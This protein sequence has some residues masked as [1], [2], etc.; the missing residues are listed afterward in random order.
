MKRALSLILIYL[1]V[2]MLCGCTIPVYPDSGLENGEKTEEPENPPTQSTKA[3]M[4]KQSYDGLR[5][6][7]Y[8]PEHPTENTPL[9]V[10]LHGGSGKGE[11]P[12]LI[13][14]VDGFPKYV[15]DGD[16]VPHAYV[17]FPQCPSDQNGWAKMSDKLE[18]LI[19]S[20]CSEL[21]ID[22]GRIS[23]TGHSMGGT[24]TWSLALSKPH[25]FYK[26]APMSGSVKLTDANVSKLSSLSIR[27]F[28][29]EADRMV[30]PE[31]SKVMISA[32]KELGADADIT[33]FLG[34]THA[35]VPA[36]G[37]LDGEVLRWLTE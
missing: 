22:E 25:L 29:G 21:P 9:L 23:L 12:E 16:L 27:A 1:L 28:V 37:Y 19:M 20:L 10:Y 6:W 35:E 36:L 15:L 13:T 11:D 31:S 34:A 8:T 17:I 18:S 5:Y 3:G 30:D 7:L 24:V 2:T 4:S 14:A 33:V 32:L 26:I